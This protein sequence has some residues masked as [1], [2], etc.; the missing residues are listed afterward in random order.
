MTYY[1]I[2]LTFST[3]HFIEGLHFTF[4][5]H[6]FGKFVP[7]FFFF[8]LYRRNQEATIIAISSE[9]VSANICFYAFFDTFSSVQI[10]FSRREHSYYFFLFSRDWFLH[11][12]C[13]RTSNHYGSFIC[14]SK[15]I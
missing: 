7:V 10:L 3:D 8:F 2:G 9:L 13:H 6:F 5:R 4:P 11:L 1:E 14:L 12:K 15:C